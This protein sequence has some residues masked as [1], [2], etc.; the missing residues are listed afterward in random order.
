MNEFI[1][2]FL[3]QNHN[4]IEVLGILAGSLTAIYI[5]YRKVLKAP[6][7]KICDAVERLYLLPSRVEHVFNELSVNSGKSIKDSIR[8]LEEVE[9]LLIRDAIS[10]LEESQLIIIDK[11]R[12][13]LD[14]HQIGLI[15]TDS[16][17][18][19]IW[20]NNTYLELVDAN[21]EDILGNGWVNVV[22]PEFREHIYNLWLDAIEQK[23]IFK[24]DFDMLIKDKRIRVRGTAYPIRFKGEIKGYLGKVQ[25]IVQ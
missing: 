7:C 17:G 18:E 22:A 5:F 3:N 9:V 6:I 8:R 1:A 16:N 21:L 13:L 20:A 15:E 4:L 14:D 11:H 10:R 2:E 24:E 25:V 19:V 23:R 12:I